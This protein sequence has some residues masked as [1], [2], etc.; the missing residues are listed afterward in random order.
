M[1]WKA[2][3]DSVA[4]QPLS[5]RPTVYVQHC[6]FSLHLLTT[7]KGSSWHLKWMNLLP[8]WN[9]NQGCS[10]STLPQGGWEVHGYNGRV[11][12]CSLVMLRWRA[13]FASFILQAKQTR[14]ELF[15]FGD[16]LI[17]SFLNSARQPRNCSSYRGCT[18]TWHEWLKCMESVKIACAS[19]TA[20]IKHWRRLHRT[21]PDAI[22]SVS[23]AKAN[24]LVIC[25]LSN[26]LICW[27]CKI[28]SPKIN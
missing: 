13:L 25:W 2:L 9:L 16:L 10:E 20:W 14:N 21:S 7:P 11:W 3:C 17:R 27:L 6:S 1:G 12:T 15:E 26:R 23:S 18:L 22:V 19:E 24:A 8:S 28:L 4:R 5:P